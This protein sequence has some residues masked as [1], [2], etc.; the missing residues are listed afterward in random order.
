MRGNLQESNGRKGMTGCRQL[1]ALLAAASL[2][3]VAGGEGRMVSRVTADSRL[4]VPGTLFVAV[5][6]DRADGHAFLADAVR[7]G[8]VAVVVERPVAGLALPAVTVANGRVALGRLAAAFHGHPASSLRVVGITGTNGK[9]TVSY[10]LEGM[11]RAAGGVPAVLGT[12]EY[13]CGDYCEPAPLTTPGPE[14][15]QELVAAMR[16]RGATHLLMEVSSHAMDQDR[17]AGM[18]CDVAVFTNLSRDH[19]DYHGDME[20]YYLAKRRLFVDY[21][22]EEG[23]AVIC[24]GGGDAG[25][26]RR[27]AEE[28]ATAWRD[29][30]LQRRRMFLCGPEGDVRPRTAALTVNGSILSIETGGETI[31]VDSPLIGAFNAENLLTAAGVGVALG[32]SAEVIGRGLSSVATVP[33]RL[34][35]VLP[36]CE[37]PVFVD[38]A[39]TP[40]ALVKVLATLGDLA[41]GRLLVVCGCGGDRD[42]GKRPQMGRA[43]AENADVV[44]LTS[45]NPRSECPAAILKEME[46]G[47]VAAGL[48]RQRLELGLAGGGGGFYDIVES[49]RTAIRLTVGGARPGDVVLI[50]GKGHEDYQ[51]IGSRRLAFDDRV[52]ATAALRARKAA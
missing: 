6:G 30:D 42:R 48:G 2:P 1:N 31:A 13:R 8:A 28:T 47:V 43:A 27:L 24:L 10:L 5:A 25:W 15:L 29:A 14:R 46:V 45:D 41:P 33:G 21:L 12:V 50:A 17:L 16:D 4:V 37:P 3:T 26:S 39:H 11:V 36:E 9:T 51:I 52:E 23:R 49:R 20:R 35:R 44:V 7:R 32:L 34:Q 38:Y 18:L 40:D 22:K 19:L